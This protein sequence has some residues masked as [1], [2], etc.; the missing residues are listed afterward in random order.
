[1]IGYA[2][3][4]EIIECQLHPTRHHL[5]ARSVEAVAIGFAFIVPGNLGI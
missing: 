5:G 2:F 4:A 1:M 3:A